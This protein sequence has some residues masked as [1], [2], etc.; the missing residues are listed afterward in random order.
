ME[1]RTQVSRLHD[2]FKPNKIGWEDGLE[3][4]LDMQERYKIWM[5][6]VT[7]VSGPDLEYEWNSLMSLLDE[8]WTKRM[9][10]DVTLN[11]K[12]QEERF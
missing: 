9:N 8:K 1:R 6:E 10:E 11:D 3:I 4:V 7:R 5:K 2:H 12:Q